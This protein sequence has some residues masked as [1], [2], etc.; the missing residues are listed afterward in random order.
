MQH[1]KVEL[2]GA[3][4]SRTTQVRAAGFPTRHI[5]REAVIPSESVKVTPDLPIAP[6]STPKQSAPVS[7]EAPKQPLA[8]L[9]QEVDA[10][11]EAKPALS[12][13]QEI[14]LKAL[15][16]STHAIDL[17]SIES[18]TGLNSLYILLSCREMAELGFVEIVSTLTCRK[19]RASRKVAKA[20]Q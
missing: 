11:M 17:E 5:F 14:I 7:T 8:E 16:K 4:G 18:M 20:V 12:Q 2:I 6:V 10:V 19:F 13:G 9:L 1:V 3:N 15:R